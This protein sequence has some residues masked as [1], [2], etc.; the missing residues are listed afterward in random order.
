MVLLSL[1]QVR[2][3][4]RRETRE[5][6]YGNKSAVCRSPEQS[7]LVCGRQENQERKAVSSSGRQVRTPSHESQTFFESR[8][9][10]D[11]RRSLGRAEGV[12]SAIQLEPITSALTQEVWFWPMNRGPEP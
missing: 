3:G 11:R 4:R 6:R 1:R 10:G 5:E 9:I 7:G 2:D 12:Q 8:R